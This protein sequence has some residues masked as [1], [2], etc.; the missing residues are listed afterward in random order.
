MS[1]PTDLTTSYPP[2]LGRI[3]ICESYPGMRDVFDLTLRKH[4]ELAFTKKPSEILSLLRQYS[5]HMVIWDLDGEGNPLAI[6]REVRQFYPNLEILLVAGEFSLA[7]QESVV[8]QCGLVG[9]LWK[10]WSPS[11]A[12]AEQVQV[13]LGDRKSS[14]RKWTLRIPC[15]SSQEPACP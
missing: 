10:P 3:L 2:K 14:L 8:K 13:M 1:I 5:F 12:V 15:T 9:F 7:F 4:Y 11:S 6:L